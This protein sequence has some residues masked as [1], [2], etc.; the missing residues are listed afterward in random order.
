MGG[1][2]GTGVR[3]RPA[4]GDVGS[5]AAHEH[6]SEIWLPPGR[7]SVAVKAETESSIGLSEPIQV[8]RPA[9]TNDQQPKLHVLAIGPASEAA[10]AAAVSKALA[11][12]APKDLG[13]AKPR[14]L[15]GAD[16]TP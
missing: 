15:Q 14:I 11:A 5:Q 16:A 7:H 12:A 1:R 10:A 3:S 8:T 13:E 6:T 4:Q 9:G 2:K